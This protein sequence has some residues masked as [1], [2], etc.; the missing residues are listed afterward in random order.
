M[1]YHTVIEGEWIQPRRKA[2]YMKCCDCGLVHRL[3]FRLVKFGKGK[4]IQFKAYRVK[5]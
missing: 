2:Y 3:E 1:K 5:K 4:K